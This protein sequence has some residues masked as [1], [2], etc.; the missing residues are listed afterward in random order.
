MSVIGDYVHWTKRGYVEPE[1]GNRD[2][3]INQVYYKT[4]FES[5]EQKHKKIQTRYMNNKH[6]QLAKDIEQQ[7][8]KT[9]ELFYKP[10]ANLTQAEKDYLEA[11]IT[12]WDN[13][14]DKEFSGLT[15]NYRTFTKGQDVFSRMQNL[16]IKSA[17]AINNNAIKAI[18]TKVNKMLNIL[19]NYSGSQTTSIKNAKEDLQNIAQDISS[20]KQDLIK[21]LNQQKTEADTNVKKAIQS[22]ITLLQN[23]TFNLVSQINSILSTFKWKN[24]TKIVGAIGEIG[25]ESIL[26][27][28]DYFASKEI[29]NSM[30]EFVKSTK[31]TAN[32]T[33]Q[34]GYDISYFPTWLDQGDWRNII[35]NNKM[36]ITSDGF[37]GT[38]LHD[39][40][41]DKAD[42]TIE[43]VD[44]EEIGVS[45]KNY[46]SWTA[47]NRGVGILKGS[48]FL[49]MV[50]NENEYDF[51]NHYI[52]LHTY[53]K[54]DAS[55][56]K[57]K[58]FKSYV[59]RVALGRDRITSA[60]KK[61]LIYK[62]FTSNEI[63]YKKKGKITKA[64]NTDIFIYIERPNAKK[65]PIIKVFTMT[66]IIDKTL[67]FI[68]IDM[69]TKI[70]QQGEET[71]QE[72]IKNILQRLHVYKVN[73]SIDFSNFNPLTERSI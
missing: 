53:S 16:K 44:G 45:I 14:L 41:K 59:S 52:N 70:I 37:A 20:I 42:I 9:E 10:E 34:T 8:I 32:A 1:F 50:Q 18:E 29:D 17:S 65:K 66:D 51:V 19:D 73:A 62:A 26:M 5:I 3:S 4:V 38:I 68:Q 46:S 11:V 61:L 43:T 64:N 40:A 13:K 58:D 7:L 48:S 31:W 27:H 54:N 25:V 21:L 72:R 30:Q 2:T 22:Q 57:Q 15:V 71:W 39:F 60:M 24:S 49:S 56:G 35:N 55:Y 6:K 33:H 47:M 36:K 67:D 69:P 63:I 28:S 23:D 12:D